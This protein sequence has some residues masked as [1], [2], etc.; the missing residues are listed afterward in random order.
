[1]RSYVTGDMGATRKPTARK[2]AGV[3]C[4]DGKCFRPAGRKAPAK[5]KSAAP[6]KK[7][8]APA[9]KSAAPAKKSAAP[10]KKSSS[11]RKAPA[12]K[13]VGRKPRTSPP[14]KKSPAAIEAAA[15]VRKVET[16]AHST[17][18]TPK[19]KIVRILK[20]TALL[21]AAA[22]A[23]YLTSVAMHPSLGG[24]LASLTRHASAAKEHIR[25]AAAAVTERIRA[26][27]AS[28]ALA[29]PRAVKNVVSTEHLE[30]NIL[31]NPASTALTIH[32]TYFP[33]DP[34]TAVMR[35]LPTSAGLPP[36]SS[37]AFGAS[38]AA[39]G[40]STRDSA[41]ALVDKV[42]ASP[43][44]AA[45]ASSYAFLSGALAAAAVGYYG[46]KRRTRGES[47]WN[48]YEYDARGANRAANIARGKEEAAAAEAELRR[49]IN[50]YRWKRQTPF[51]SVPSRNPGGSR[52]NDARPNSALR[53][54]G[55]TRY[56]NARS[57][58]TRGYAGYA[59]PTRRRPSSPPRALPGAYPFPSRR[60]RNRL[61]QDPRVQVARND[62]VRDYDA[63]TLA[64]AMERGP[65]ADGGQM[66]RY[67]RVPTMPTLVATRN[68]ARNGRLPG[69]SR[70]SPPRARTFASSPRSSPP[71]ARSLPGTRN[72]RALY[73]NGLE[74]GPG[75]KRLE[76]QK[77][78]EYEN[79]AGPSN[80][81]GNGLSAMAGYQM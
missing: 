47:G 55:T 24:I 8:A 74:R 54:P 30:Q 69:G 50:S 79:A 12:T 64:D 51:P 27:A 28:T 61:F 20:I 32:K 46:L 25:Y 67:G 11:T 3:V 4:V 56:E 9:K 77:K 81:P 10:A 62:F 17:K 29:I 38:T 48:K 65:Y 52:A 19:Q 6:A 31:W 7:S 73:D 36:M 39:F 71:R 37:A 1:M 41:V 66:Y 76:K 15:A 78:A 22:L 2:P 16:I 43:L 33:P 44:G 70:S 5:K 58:P 18:M 45:A 23:V 13:S 34:S 42:L 72:L 80:A 21:G 75:Q 40:A 14:K 49:N 68:L 59:A 26:S 60:D 35:Y 53:M 57:A 63:G